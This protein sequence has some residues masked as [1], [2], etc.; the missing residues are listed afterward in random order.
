MSR[1]PLKLTAAQ[2]VEAAR[3]E[4]AEMSVAEAQEAVARGDA[5]LVDIRDVRELARE[6]RIPGSIHCPRGML[7]FWIDPQSPYF[8]PVFAEPKTYIF[9]CAM[10]WRSALAAKTA[11]DM[12][13][14]PVAHL[15]GGLQAWKA[16]GGAIEPGRES[17]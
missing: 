8:K 4:I 17:E 14:G 2:L 5:V 11:Q 9:H 1:D 13:F 7:E 10:D 16:A 6:G 3:A 15:K 12:G